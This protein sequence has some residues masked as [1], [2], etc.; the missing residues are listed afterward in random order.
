M[1]RTVEEQSFMHKGGY[2][3]LRQLDC[4]RPFKKST[5]ESQFG[6]KPVDDAIRL[7]LLEIRT[8]SKDTNEIYVYITARGIAVRDK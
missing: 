5:L 7:R 6:Q 8:N 1:K 2:G 4:G 3:L